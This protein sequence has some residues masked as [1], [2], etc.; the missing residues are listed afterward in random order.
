M[1]KVNKY[2]YNG[3]CIKSCSEI[4]ATQNV[5]FICQETNVNNTYIS[6]N[7]IYLDKNETIKDIQTLAM[8][9]AQEFNYTYKHIFVCKNN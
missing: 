4:E 2:L 5:S 3:N 8:T 7:P 9:Y 6:E 1:D